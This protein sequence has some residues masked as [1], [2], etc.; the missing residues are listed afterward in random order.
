MWSSMA[1]E[2]NGKGR[3]RRIGAGEG[4]IAHFRQICLKMRVKIRGC[5][6]LTVLGSRLPHDPQ[7]PLYVVPNPRPVL[8]G[9]YASCTNSVCVILSPDV[10]LDG[11]LCV[12]SLQSQAAHMRHH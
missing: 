3:V 9:L 7:V 11:G 2:N 10:A 5:A 12:G 8:Q 1:L 4:E 6:A